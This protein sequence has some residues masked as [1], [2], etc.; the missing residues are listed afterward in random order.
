MIICAVLGAISEVL[1]FCSLGF[2]MFQRFYL[3]PGFFLT[4]FWIWSLVARRSAPWHRYV[5]AFATA[6]SVI[7]IVLG[8]LALAVPVVGGLI[9]SG[10]PQWIAELNI[11]L[12]LALAFHFLIF[13]CCLDVTKSLNPKA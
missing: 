3:V 1:L 8:L 10:M 4:L 7:W 9:F 13:G 2:S 5:W 12:F 6:W 11:N